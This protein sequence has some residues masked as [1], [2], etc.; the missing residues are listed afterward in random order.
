METEMTH[1]SSRPTITNLIGSPDCSSTYVPDADTNKAIELTRAEFDVLLEQQARR[2][3]DLLS[4][5]MSP[6]VGTFYLRALG[7]EAP[8]PETFDDIEDDDEEDQSY[9]EWLTECA[10]DDKRMG[11]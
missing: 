1:G 4:A 9:E 8:E 10:I 6:N 7:F 5:V 11:E 3:A 2:T